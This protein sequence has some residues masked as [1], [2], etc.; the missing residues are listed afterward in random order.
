MT[1]IATRT[2]KAKYET[3]DGSISRT[4]AILCHSKNVKEIYYQYED[5]VEVPPTDEATSDSAPPVPAAPAAPTATAS[6]APP[7]GPVTS[8]EDV[9]VNAIDILLVVAQ[10]LKKRVDEIPLSKTI[11]D[12]VG[13]KSTLQNEILGDLQQ[14]FASAREKG[15]ELP[16]EELSSALGSGFNGSLGKYSTGL[17]SRLV[18]SKMPGGFN[19]SSIKGYLSKTWGLGPSRS[20]G[21]LPATTLEP[22]K[23][24][25]SEA[26]AKA[27]LDGVVSV[28]AQRTGISLSSP[29]AAGAGGGGGAVINSEKFLKFQA[30]QEKFTAQHVELY[31]RYL[32]RD[33]RAGELAFDE[34]RANSVALQ[35][36]LDNITRE[37][38]DAYIEGIQP[39]FDVLKAR[40][41]DSSWNWVRQDALLMFYD[42][43]FG[44]LTTVDREITARCIAL[45]NRADPSMLEYMQYHIDHCDPSKGETYKLAK[46]FGLCSTLVCNL[47]LSMVSCLPVVLWSPRRRIPALCQGFDHWE[48]PS[49]KLHTCRQAV[50]KVRRY[51]LQDAQK[52]E[53][54]VVRH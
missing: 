32:G 39:H 18:G 45:L 25:A 12:L 24:L 16:L 3:A 42:I 20:D 36:K 52:E 15:E 6:V 21:V 26:E 40:H 10:K 30:D 37:H 49:T 5:E 4:R 38:G 1:G 48:S 53:G 2:H 33:S 47:C 31:M 43:I 54:A 41:F 44:R 28:Y 51:C 22:P 19:T 13:G 7:T 27:W 29:G 34:E 9:P 35:A 23:C 17:I 8:I 11:K 46:E 50:E 14:E